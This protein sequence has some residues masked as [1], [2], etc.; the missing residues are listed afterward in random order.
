MIQTKQ[1]SQAAISRLQWTAIH[2]VLA[3]RTAICERQHAEAKRDPG[4]RDIAPMQAGN[5]NRSA[6]ATASGAR[7]GQRAAPDR[8]RILREARSCETW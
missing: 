7:F 8:S 4:S 6:M 3:A 5:K 1:E 2:F